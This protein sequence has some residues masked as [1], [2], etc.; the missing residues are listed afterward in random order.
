MLINTIINYANYFIKFEIEMFLNLVIISSFPFSTSLYQLL[1]PTFQNPKGHNYLSDRERDIL[2]TH[3]STWVEKNKKRQRDAYVASTV[4]PEI[5]ALDPE[6]FGV[7]Q[8][9]KDKHIKELWDRKV[10]V[11]I[12]LFS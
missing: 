10:K 1:M 4:L 8:L 3:L 5:Q 7:D 6:R 12:N 2:G 11:T 9:S